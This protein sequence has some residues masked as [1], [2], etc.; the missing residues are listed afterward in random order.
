LALFE[1]LGD[2]SNL[3]TPLVYLGHMALHGGDHERLRTL[4]REAEALRGELADPRAS[5]FLVCFLGAA[6]L[7]EGERDRAVD[8]LEESVILNRKQGDMRDTA[9]SLTFLG[10][11][12][13]ERGD[14]ERAAALYE[15]DMRIMRGLRDKAGIAYG[16]QGM[17]GVATLRA[18]A[19]RAARL[20][21][22]AEALRE[23][24]GLPLS[25]FDRAHPDYE[26]LLS[27]A[28]SRL[29]DEAAWE[30]A[31]AEGREMAPEEA[32]EYALRPPPRAP[33]DPAT[34]PVYPAGL[35]AREVEVLR[36]LAQG[37]TNAQIAQELYIS[38]RTVN[39]H[40]TSAYHKIGSR[41]RAEAARFASEH[42]LLL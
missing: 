37:M 21:G 23:A 3:A 13:L 1:E 8:L 27:V 31:W 18:D 41:S 7:S 11:A 32:I 36:L 34:P 17:A 16:L 26:A 35:S 10:V 30:A 9:V 29:G 5:G 2:K 12:M 15:E 42:G 20:S 4:R 6:A 24:I 39:G 19:A 28:R 40:L 33:E 22:A 38:P 25:H 14:A